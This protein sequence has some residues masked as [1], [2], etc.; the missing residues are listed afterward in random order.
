MLEIVLAVLAIATLC[1]YFVNL[2]S[3]FFESRGIKYYRGIPGIG[4]MMDIYLKKQHMVENY[5]ALYNKFSD[6][7]FVKFR[8]KA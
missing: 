7:K 3:D 5:R 8:Y 4:I 6:R 1:Y 2:N